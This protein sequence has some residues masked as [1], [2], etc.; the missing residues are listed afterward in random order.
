METFQLKRAWVDGSF[1]NSG[2]LPADFAGK[3]KEGS[4]TT[5]VTGDPSKVARGFQRGWP[6][7]P[8]VEG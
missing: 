7:T 3:K 8:G 4:G 1:G 6:R 2:S 5:S